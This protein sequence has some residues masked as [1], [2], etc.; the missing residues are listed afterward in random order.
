[1]KSYRKLQQ[2]FVNE[3]SRQICQY[4]LDDSAQLYLR[5]LRRIYIFWLSNRYFGL[6]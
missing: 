4:F 3:K 5:N 6:S 1:M 2:G